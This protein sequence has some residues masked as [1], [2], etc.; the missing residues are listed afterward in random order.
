MNKV[1]IAQANRDKSIIGLQSKISEVYRFMIED[2]QLEKIIS[3]KDILSQTSQ[4]MLE[5]AKFIQSYSQPDFCKWT[6]LHCP[7]FHK[8][9]FMQ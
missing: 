4:V 7:R 8:L 3:T 2:G 6:K 5:C 1:I 9:T